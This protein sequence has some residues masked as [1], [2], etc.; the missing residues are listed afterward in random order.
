M[1][2]VSIQIIKS[3]PV[4]AQREHSSTPD[5]GVDISFTSHGEAKNP[6]T[7]PSSSSLSPAPNPLALVSPA[8]PSLAAYAPPSHFPYPLPP[9]RLSPPYPSSRVP[10]LHAA[11]RPSA[12][13]SIFK[14]VPPSMSTQ[15]RR[16]WEGYRSTVKRHNHTLFV[17]S[18]MPL[19]TA[20]ME[21]PTPLPTPLIASPTAP[22]MAEGPIM[23]ASAVSGQRWARKEEYNTVVFLVNIGL[24]R[25]AHFCS[26]VELKRE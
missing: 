6:A 13:P 15:L 17:A 9:I 14:A 23:R 26:Y 3:R 7:F 25:H 20:V 22:T 12:N 21:S 4:H 16:I 1:W 24:L 10:Y 11:K 2:P 18:P 19:D 8:V 5:L